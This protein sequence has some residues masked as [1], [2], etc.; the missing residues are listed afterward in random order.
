MCWDVF[1]DVEYGCGEEAGSGREGVVNVDGEGC[2]GG[3]EE[4]D[5]DDVDCS[6][7]DE[8]GLVGFFAEVKADGGGVV[9]GAGSGG[10]G[11]WE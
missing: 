7:A 6:V 4:S 8:E 11:G 1:G 9:D 2:G 10:E 3:G 5:C